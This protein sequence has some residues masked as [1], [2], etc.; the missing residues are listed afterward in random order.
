[1][2]WRLDIRNNILL[3]IFSKFLTRLD[4]LFVQ[5][6][7]CVLSLPRTLHFAF[8]EVITVYIT[9][10]STTSLNLKSVS[11]KDDAKVQIVSDHFLKVYE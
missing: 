10:N 2:R 11:K 9:T 8:S 7:C 5:E 1:M 3:E 4:F 6:I